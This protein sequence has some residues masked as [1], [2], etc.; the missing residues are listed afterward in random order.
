MSQ[1]KSC[2]I[3]PDVEDVVI[4]SASLA[5]SLRKLKHDLK[6]CRSCS[7]LDSCNLRSDFIKKVN[8]AISE[9]QAEFD[10]SIS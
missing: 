5:K 9:V 7:F 8:T 6:L 2:P 10:L 1:N 3:K 4:N